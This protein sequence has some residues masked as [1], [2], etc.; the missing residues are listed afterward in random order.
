MDGY[1][2]VVVVFV[3]SSLD[4]DCV[5]STVG[6]GIKPLTHGRVITLS[7]HAKVTKDDRVQSFGALIIGGNGN[8]VGGYGYGRGKSAQLALVDGTHR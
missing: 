8:G 4:F 1:S 2:M 3:P 6:P 7:T 5:S